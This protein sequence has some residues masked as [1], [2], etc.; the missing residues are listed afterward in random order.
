MSIKQK[1]KDISTIWYAIG[2]LVATVSLVLAMKSYFASA[3]D[4]EK[5]NLTIQQ[6]KDAYQ[7]DKNTAR[8]KFLDDEIFKLQEK[9][10]GKIMPTETRERV[11]QYEQEYKTI[12]RKLEEVK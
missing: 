10:R 6:M 11:H 4:L 8:Y 9:Y 5:T 1:I 3:G 7:T 12:E 2:I